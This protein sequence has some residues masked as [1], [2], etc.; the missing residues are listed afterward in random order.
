MPV[1]TL[2]MSDSISIAIEKGSFDG[3]MVKWDFDNRGKRPISV[4]DT[5]E[6][7]K[8]MSGLWDSDAYIKVTVTK[9]FDKL[10]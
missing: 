1:S 7:A 9:V 6:R 5:L 8:I 10:P 3:Y 4:Y 2:G